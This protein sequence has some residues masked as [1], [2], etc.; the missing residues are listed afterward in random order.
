MPGAM[1]AAIIGL[2]PLQINQKICKPARGLVVSASASVLVVPRPCKGAV[3]FFP[4]ARCAERAAG[5][6]PRPQNQNE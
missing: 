2:L 3:A 4:G 1:T 5:N 6:I